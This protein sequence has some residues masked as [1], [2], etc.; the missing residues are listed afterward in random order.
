MIARHPSMINHDMDW[1][2]HQCKKCLRHE[3]RIVRK[4]EIECTPQMGV[5]PR[6]QSK[7]QLTAAGER[8]VE[9]L[10][11]VA[12]QALTA[13]CRRDRSADRN[14]AESIAMLELVEAV[15]RYNPNRNDDLN[16]H[17]YARVRLGLSGWRCTRDKWGAKNKKNR[18]RMGSLIPDIEG[19]ALAVRGGDQIHT[20]SLEWAQ[21]H[22][23]AVD[24]QDHVEWLLGLDPKRDPAVRL[25]IVEGRPEKE[26]AAILGQTERNVLARVNKSL[27]RIREALAEKGGME[28]HAHRI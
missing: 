1:K 6:G 27:A 13:H 26:V 18:P 7:Y 14:E 15:A 20:S 11:P 16:S 23:S 19:G 9:T 10:K 17:V 24:S 3:K 5:V 28:Y 4:G 21:N 22:E 12:N 25:R 8:A 2:R